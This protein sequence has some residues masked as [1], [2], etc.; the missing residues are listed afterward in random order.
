MSVKEKID[1]WIK[2]D[3]NGNIALLIVV[4]VILI[5]GLVMLSS[6]SSATAYINFG[7]SYHFAKRQLMW[8]VPG[9]LAFLITS[10]IDYHLWRRFSPFML[11]ASICLLLLVFLPWFQAD[12]GSARS[13]IQIF[14]LSFQPSELVKITFILYLAAWLESRRDRL[15]KESIWPF[16][17]IFGIIILLMVLQP[18]IG[19]LSIISV[20]SLSVYYVGGGKLSHIITIALVGIIGLFLLI[21]VKDYQKERLL[22]YQNPDYDP[23]DTCYQINQSLIAVGSGGLFGRGLGESRQK[24]LYQSGYSMKLIL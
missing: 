7:D 12:W 10:K 21:S 9:I 22:C 1:S 16:A 19:T 3:L 18:D 8:F 4:G 24:F 14:G 20:T 13:W 17:T 23:Q 15:D 5:F 11:V 6:A 2:P